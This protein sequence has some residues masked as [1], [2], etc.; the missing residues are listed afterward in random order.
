MDY[1]LGSITVAKPLRLAKVGS[2]LSLMSYFYM[3]SFT[4][5]RQDSPAVKNRSRLFGK[6]LVASVN[7]ESLAVLVFFFLFTFAALF[8]RFHEFGFYEDDY[9]AIV[10]YLQA[11]WPAV[12]NTISYVFHAWPIGRPLN[13]ALPTLMT[14]VGMKLGGH[15]GICFLS[16]LVIYANTILIWVLSRKILSPASA[17]VAATLYLLYPADTTKMFTEHNSHVHFSV[18]LALIG[19][20]LYYRRKRWLAYPVAAMCL[21]SYETAFLPFAILPTLLQLEKLNAWKNRLWHVVLCSAILVACFGFRFF[22]LSEERAQMAVGSPATMVYRSITSFGIGPFYALQTYG[23]AFSRGLSIHDLLLTVLIGIL[24]VIGAFLLARFLTSQNSQSENQERPILRPLLATFFTWVFSYGL[25]FVNYPPTDI[26][27]R[28][29]S[30][31][32]AAGIA[33]ALLLA[34]IF[35][36][37]ARRRRLHPLFLPAGFAI[38]VTLLGWYH[39]AMQD[40]YAVA[41]QNEKE[42]WRQIVQQAPDLD[43]DTRVIVFGSW[44]EVQRPSIFSNSWADPLVLRYVYRWKDGKYP[45]LTLADSFWQGLSDFK[46]KEGVVS[47]RP[48]YWVPHYETIEKSRTILFVA[49]RNLVR[50]VTEWKINSLAASVEGRPAVTRQNENAHRLTY[51]GRLLLQ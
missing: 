6:A 40:D 4:D 45:S 33:H 28:L 10:P 22:I 13:Y 11:K 34:C 41:W 32:I 17:F 30:V 5:E 12:F 49:S 29:T 19:L 46:I 18:T 24:A 27:G 8:A 3:P 1:D 25:T 20:N 44:W 35:E 21:L 26:H 39:V 37:I 36:W 14:F 42:Y 31:H 15:A 51:F 2:F 38:L 47:Y 23:Y 9:W 48:L 16:F 50:R 7:R 43:E